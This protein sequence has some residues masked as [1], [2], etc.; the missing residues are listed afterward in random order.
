MEVT[1]EK[2]LKEELKKENK[3]TEKIETEQIIAEKSES[4]HPEKSKENVVRN[5]GMGQKSR[6]ISDDKDEDAMSVRLHTFD[7]SR[8]GVITIFDT[9]TG[10]K[11]DK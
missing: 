4:Q 2:I 11:N 1:P 10:K 9:I 8:T 5:R 3:I 7:K 6:G